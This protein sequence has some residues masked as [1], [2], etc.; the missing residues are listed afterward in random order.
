LPEGNSILAWGDFF[1]NCEDKWKAAFFVFQAMFVGT[2]ATIVS[3]ACAGR[4]RLSSYLLISAV[5][6]GIIYPIFGHWAWGS[7]LHDNP[8]WLEN[9]G[10]KDFAGSTV[11]HSVGAWVGLVAIWLIGP[12]VDK[13]DE[14]G[15]PRVIQPSNYVL[16]ICGTLILFFGWFFFNGG[17]TLLLRSHEELLY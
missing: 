3:G 12:R 1:I 2:G 6:S 10:F 8:G 17:S 7:L 16:A 14:K 9:L 5:V 4:T 11:V 15:N 13:F